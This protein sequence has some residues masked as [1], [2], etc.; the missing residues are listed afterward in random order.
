MLWHTKPGD[1]VYEPF[2]G[3]GT[4]I[5]AAEMTD[6]RCFAMEQEPAYVDVAVR[7]WE[8]FTGKTAER[9]ENALPDKDEN[10]RTYLRGAAAYQH[11][12]RPDPP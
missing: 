9:I 7:R 3:S 12:S 8:Q 5:I 1:L 2:L 6:R 11:R 10:H 4:A